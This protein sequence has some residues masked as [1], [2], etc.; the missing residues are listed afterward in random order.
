MHI[1]KLLLTLALCSF[2][3]AAIAQ[4]R[5]EKIWETDS[6]Y[7]VPE[8]IHFEPQEGILYVSLVDGNSFKKDGTGGIAKADTNGT[9]LD[10]AFVAGLDAPK[11]MAF[12]GDKIYVADLENLVIADKKSGKVL[13]KIAV[14]H[15]GM[16]NDVVADQ[17]GNIYVSD[18]KAGKIYR[19]TQ[20]EPNV[21]LDSLI[22]PNGLL[23]LKDALYYLDNGALY[24]Y[25]KGG[26]PV[27]VASN[28]ALGL[29]GLQ[30]V[31]KNTFLASAWAGMVYF[32]G[33][34]GNTPLLLDKRAEKANMA[35]FYYNAQT[36]TLYVPT[37]Y[38]KTI[39]AYKL[40]QP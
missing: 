31:G 7:A 12:V 9:L 27:A 10:A 20:E 30:Q 23:W 8:S 13:K 34:K 14:P 36:K 1:P 5:L 32:V 11:G 15:A 16:L 28:M 25:K 39:A 2:Y 35:D 22:N 26:K 38:R 17:K 6:V 18:S 29:D 4:P 40:M 3:C 21:Y 33:P 19:F 24:K 37:F